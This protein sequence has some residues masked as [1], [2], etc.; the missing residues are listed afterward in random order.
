MG[1]KGERPYIK[2]PSCGGGVCPNVTLRDKEGEGRG[3]VAASLR[4][5]T[6]MCYMAV[7]RATQCE[8]VRQ[9]HIDDFDRP[10]FDVKTKK[11]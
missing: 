6:L 7:P 2:S 1:S 8:M 11:F 10:E 9:N 4:F 3:W 5:V